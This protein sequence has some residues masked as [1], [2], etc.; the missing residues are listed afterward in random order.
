MNVI[1]LQSG[2][3]GN[4]FFVQSGDVSLVFD[5]GISG[6]A[7]EERLKRHQRDIRQAQGLIISHDHR[8]HAQSMGIFQR[9]FGL[10]VYVTRPTLDAARKWCSLG[11]LDDVRHF[12][13]GETLTFEHVVVHS[14]PTPHDGADGV[15]F[16]IDDG[17]RR[18]GILTDLGHPFKGLLEILR[19]LDA[20]VIESNYDDEMLESGTYSPALK[21]RIRGPHG[22]LSNLEAARLVQMAGNRLQWA[23]ICHLSEENNHPQRAYDTHRE[24]VGEALPIYVAGRYAA[25]NVL[26]L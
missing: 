24:V 3:N 2:S 11:R 26:D 6:R 1:S 17:Q 16:V 12:C 4:C 9:K 13:S 8:D 15:A 10:P 22:H 25:T 21:R 18:L 23:C 7:A 19:S 5:A 14:I 20:V